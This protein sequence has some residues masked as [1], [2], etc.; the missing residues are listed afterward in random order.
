MN[1]IKNNSILNNINASD[2]MKNNIL[3]ACV[4]KKRT[5]NLAF[6]YSKQMVAACTALVII[7]AGSTA[8]AGIT[9]HQRLAAMTQEEKQTYVQVE[10]AREGDE[11]TNFNRKLNQAEHERMQ[12]LL[13]EYKN[14]RF[15]ESDMKQIKTEAEK[16]ADELCF[17]EGTGLV[18]LPDSELNDEQLLQLI[19][20]CEKKSY[21]L[22]EEFDARLE[23]Y[24]QEKIEEAKEIKSVA[25]MDVDDF[26]TITKQFM[27]DYL[28]VTVDDSYDVLI[29]PCENN[30]YDV[31]YSKEGGSGFFS[32]MVDA[33]SIV[34]LPEGKSKVAYEDAK[35][36]AAEYLKMY[37]DVTVASV[38]AIEV[39][40]MNGFFEDAAGR[41]SCT[42]FDADNSFYQL[43]IS[44]ET[45]KAQMVN[46]A[47][48]S[49]Y[50]EE[51]DLEQLSQMTD[52]NLSIAKEYMASHFS[53]LGELK[54]TYYRPFCNIS[55]TTAEEVV[56]AFE[57]ENGYYMVIVNPAVSR[58]TSFQMS[59]TKEH[60]EKT[61]QDEEIMPFEQLP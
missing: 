37:C 8:Y 51:Y 41:Y 23:A 20:F 26:H 25:E 35:N 18:Y 34:N 17:V 29:E 42:Y 3:D 38:D 54:V 24:R 36:V 12:E 56:F 48:S 28:G 43:D 39:N 16:E 59:E 53:D 31:T 61:F 1:S 49:I 19:D 45:G 47:G 32:F 2:T 27:Q 10:D 9:Y 50:Y 57:Y 52:E 14:G 13:E 6:R 4:N 21:A 7:A 44:C 30:K 46:E 11:S 15:P 55:D 5:S 33:E 60:F 22:D 58:V 40:Y